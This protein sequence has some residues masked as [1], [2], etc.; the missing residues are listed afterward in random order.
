MSWT[1]LP[2]SHDLPHEPHFWYSALA[3]LEGPGPITTWAH[4]C[5]GRDQ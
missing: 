4:L 2:C 1:P 5:P 3:G